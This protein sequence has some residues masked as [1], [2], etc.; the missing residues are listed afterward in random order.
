MS[1]RALFVPLIVIVIGGWC[2]VEGQLYL[3]CKRK[4]PGTILPHPLGCT[5]FIECLDGEP[6]LRYC[7][8]GSHYSAANPPCDLIEK[9]NCKDGST[10]SASAS[11][12]STIPS[13]SEDATTPF[14]PAPPTTTVRTTR[15]TRTPRPTTVAP[16]ATLPTT[17]PTPPIIATTQVPN[18]QVPTTRTSTRKTRRTRTTST[19]TTTTTTV[20][21][22]TTTQ[23]ST[24]T[25]I[26]TTVETSPETP[27]TN[28]PIQPN[29]LERGI[30]C[31]DNETADDFVIVPS[32]VDCTK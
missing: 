6:N 24:N 30:K 31:P 20:T 21:I 4:P 25:T 23:A 3:A 2:L 18:S 13:T 12:S 27:A 28:K 9:A 26:P 11:S 7:P 10:T 8:K 14:V 15:R 22:P 32:N 19:T 17:Q 16:I 1:S 29:R 5:H